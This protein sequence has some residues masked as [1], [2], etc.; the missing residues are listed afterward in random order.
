MRLKV[1]TINHFWMEGTILPCHVN[2]GDQLQHGLRQTFR[3]HIQLTMDVFH[4]GCTC[5][6]AS[7]LDLYRGVLGDVQSHGSS[8]LY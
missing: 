6:A 2:E 1:I 3:Y 8:G 5:P 4:E 7:S